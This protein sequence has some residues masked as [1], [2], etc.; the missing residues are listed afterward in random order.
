MIAGCPAIECLMIYFVFGV[1]RLKINALRLRI[2][3]M[4]TYSHDYY[5]T[6]EPQLEN[7]VIENAPCL[8]RLI[9]ADQFDATRVSVISAPKLETFGY[10]NNDHPSFSWNIKVLLISCIAICTTKN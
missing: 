1:N 8:T 9:R 2:I 7:L 6:A 3:G 10:V 5:S 4:R